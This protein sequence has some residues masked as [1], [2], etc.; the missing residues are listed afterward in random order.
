VVKA[1]AVTSTGWLDAF[2]TVIGLK[3]DC[4]YT[5]LTMNAGVATLDMPTGATAVLEVLTLLWMVGTGY[6]L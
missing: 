3:T 6:P 2:N 1:T 4:P 5:C